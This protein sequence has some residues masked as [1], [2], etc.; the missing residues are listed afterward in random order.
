MSWCQERIEIEKDFTW[1][2]KLLKKYEKFNQYEDEINETIILIQENEEL[3]SNE[4]KS[5]IVENGKETLKQIKTFITE[6]QYSEED[7]QDCFIEIHSGAGGTEAQ[8]WAEMLMDMYIKWSTKKNLNCQI[9]EKTSG[10][11]AGIRSCVLKFQSTNERRLIYGILK[12]E[13]GIHRLVRISPFNA[14]GL[15]HTSFAAVDV[16]P[17]VD[18]Q[19]EV[20]IEDKD[21]RIDTYR[22][23]GA[24][25][26]H[27]NTTDSAVRIVHIPTG[28]VA[29]S[30]AERSQHQ[31]KKTAMSM[32]R[33]KL[34]AFYEQQREEANKGA[35]KVQM[36]WSNQTRS[37]VLHP[38][39][40][41]KDYVTNKE[42]SRAYDVL[43]GEL[44][45]V[46]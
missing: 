38:Y 35:T 12:L 21:L 28:I 33:S 3:F 26:Q 42:T 22:S 29:Q 27:V 30:Q 10:N 1:Y 39:I 23:S 18:D 41:V 6:L 40:L 5:Q 44:E 25:G 14:N 31:N 46:H 9:I 43:G 19:I 7:Y 17:A 15:R 2:E 24:G 45:L 32:L 37:Y 34:Y 20:N 8:D 16:F 36:G 13:K 11:V 4:D